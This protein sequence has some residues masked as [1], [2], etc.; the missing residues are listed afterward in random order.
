MA[1]FYERFSEALEHAKGGMESYKAGIATGEKCPKCGTG[2]LKER[3]SRHGFFLGCS[4]YPDCDY[5]RDISEP[6]VEE[7]EGQP[8]TEYCPNCGREMTMKR[9]RFGPFLACSGYPACKTTRRLVAGSRKPRQPDV[10]LE[11]KCPECGAQLVKRQGRYGEFVGC[12]AYPKCK[13]IRAKTLGSS[14]RSLNQTL[15]N[16]V[17]W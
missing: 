7:A 2:E 4:N 16:R 6:G 17:C 10:M 3:I 12:S 15:P 14:P 9:G 11:E 5:T 8:E 1:E 13:Y